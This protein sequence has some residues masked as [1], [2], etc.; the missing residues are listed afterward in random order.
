M[1]KKF[2]EGDIPRIVSALEGINR[3]LNLIITQGNTTSDD[4]KFTDKELVKY[5]DDT[6][7]DMS[8][9]ITTSFDESCLSRLQEEIQEMRKRLV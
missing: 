4:T 2:Y 6:L 1:G 5:I 9:L 3:N 8:N 7:K